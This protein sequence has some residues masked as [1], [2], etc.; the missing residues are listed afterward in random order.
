MRILYEVFEPGYGAQWVFNTGPGGEPVRLVPEA[1]YGAEPA[2]FVSEMGPGVTAVNVV[3]GGPPAAERARY[4]APEPIM[5]TGDEMAALT[6]AEHAILGPASE[7]WGDVQATEGSNPD[8]LALC[9]Q[10]CAD[11]LAYPWNNAMWPEDLV[12]MGGNSAVALLR[13]HGDAARSVGPLEVFSQEVLRRDW[14]F[15]GPRQV[16]ERDE[17]QNILAALPAAQAAVRPPAPPTPPPEKKRG[18]FGRK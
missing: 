7:A 15:G 4:A 14:L 1:G 13:M 8:L 18:W 6:E 5:P 17:A 11:G 12:M 3:E 10:R 2:F 16:L 9:A